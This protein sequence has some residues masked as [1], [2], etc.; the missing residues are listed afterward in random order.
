MALYGG[1]AELGEKPGLNWVIGSSNTPVSPIPAESRVERQSGHRVMSESWH[2]AFGVSD[3]RRPVGTEVKTDNGLIFNTTLCNSNAGLKQT[4]F[5]LLERKLY[6][7]AP[8]SKA[9]FRR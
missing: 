7:P 3:E 4:K 9:A 8:N 6:S 1:T 5:V 2:C